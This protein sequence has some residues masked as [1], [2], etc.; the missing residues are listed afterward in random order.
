MAFELIILLKRTLRTIHGISTNHSIRRI[1]R[2]HY[3][4][5]YTSTL[6]DM[7]H[8]S[9]SSHAHTTA[10]SQPHQPTQ[11]YHETRDL[12]EMLK[13]ESKLV[14][15]FVKKNT[16]QIREHVD[17]LTKLIQ[18][19]HVHNNPANTIHQYL[20]AGTYQYYYCPQ[21]AAVYRRPYVERVF[22]SEHQ[23]RLDKQGKNG[24]ECVFDVST[25]MSRYFTAQSKTNS[26][27]TRSGQKQSP[28]VEILQTK[29]SSDNRYIA[30][31]VQP[32]GQTKNICIIKDMQTK[33]LL[34]VVIPAGQGDGS[35][36]KANNVVG[37]EFAEVQT[38][39]GCYVLCADSVGRP[40]RVVLVTNGNKH[41]PTNDT[42]NN[43]KTKA[44]EKLT[45]SGDVYQE[46]DAAFFVELYT[47]RDRSCVFISSQSRTSSEV[48]VC[49]N[50]DTPSRTHRLIP[51]QPGVV[52]FADCCNNQFYISKKKD[53]E[54]SLFTA[55]KQ[56]MHKQQE[57]LQ[58]LWPPCADT[59]TPHHQ[60]THI[61]TTSSTYRRL[62]QLFAQTQA[63][64]DL[65]H[66][67]SMMCNNYLIDDYEIFRDRVLVYGRL[68]GTV[69][70]CLLATNK[71][72]P[73]RNTNLNNDE[74]SNDPHVHAHGD[75]KDANNTAMVLDL[76]T[77]IKNCLSSS[78]ETQE[79]AYSVL[80]AFE[81]GLVDVQPQSGSGV[82]DR[83][84]HFTMSSTAF[85]QGTHP[86]IFSYISLDL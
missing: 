13:T 38:G 12:T 39:V 77:A 75:L 47:A 76:R 8:G 61:Q 54:L 26:S 48:L 73:S 78:T 15:E 55:Y 40:C 34:D 3:V 14:Q 50:A 60:Q 17:N 45:Y 42:N 67:K 86:I 84:A 19:L 81:C 70:L 52:A 30:M 68:G 82:D 32:H 16:A 37:I 29:V 24:D 33:M 57:N 46:E 63:H 27:N 72:R 23:H 51:C 83:Y 66:L 56:D 69:C 18:C 10:R 43:S 85:L 1:R 2:N 36:N 20:I 58:Q 80:S 49:T 6:T 11:S 25:E 5:R 64:I 62:R 79:G 21:T 22:P 71:T 44:T 7:E 59:H 28:Q 31:I 35:I 74:D 53:G 9:P 41:A 4:A 65:W